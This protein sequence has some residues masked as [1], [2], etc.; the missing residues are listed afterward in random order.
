MASEKQ[1][2]S[3]FLIDQWS[4]TCSYHPIEQC[5]THLHARPMYEALKPFAHMFKDF[6]EETK[7]ISDDKP[8]CEHFAKELGEGAPTMGDVRKAQALL[9]AVGLGE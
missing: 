9:A 2:V 8:L 3:S 7:Y 6:F 4:C 1:E 5:L